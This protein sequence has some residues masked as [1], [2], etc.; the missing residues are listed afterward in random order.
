MPPKRKAASK[1]SGLVD[2]DGED[3]MQIGGNQGAPAHE[4]P[5]AEPP[6]KKARGRPKS[7][8][9]KVAEAKNTAAKVRAPAA[10]APKQ[11][12]PPKKPAGRGRPK[13]VR[14]LQPE[15]EAE[16]QAAADVESEAA[17]DVSVEEEAL[18]AQPDASN[19][20]LESPKN[21]AKPKRPGRPPGT[22]GRKRSSSMKE[23]RTDGEF[24]YTPSAP[25][26]A[27][28]AGKP[29]NET[30]RPGRRKAELKSHAIPESDKSMP[31]VEESILPEE[32]PASTQTR[33]ASS[34]PLKSRANGYA[35]SR[36]AQDTNRRRGPGA[37]SDTEKIGEPE[38]RRKL[39]DM[40]KKYESLEAKFRNLRE[41]GI[42]EANT[43]AEKMRKQCEAA[44]AGM[45]SCLT[46]TSAFILTSFQLQMNLSNP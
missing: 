46:R 24:E 37:A 44:T 1:I 38:L 36:D 16:P 4:E 14:T 31:E 42:V 3:V 30:K 29:E 34:S 39:G 22:R 5:A 23:V 43:N 8:P 17:H 20:E 41:I 26:H 7:A 15:T 40:T 10:T 11:D 28:F 25:K 2:S 12:A 19:D 9:P 21:V 33:P 18:Q 32:Q 27:E 45:M 13:T 35:A 6:V